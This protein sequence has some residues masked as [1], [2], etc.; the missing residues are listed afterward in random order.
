MIYDAKRNS[1]ID[2]ESGA[3]IPIY[4]GDAIPEFVKVQIQ[5]KND[6]ALALSL[7]RSTPVE[8]DKAGYNGIATSDIV[9]LSGSGDPRNDPEMSDEEFKRHE[10]LFKQHTSEVAR[11][12]QIPEGEGEDWSFARTLQAMEFEMFNEVY[13]ARVLGREFNEKE[14]RASSTRRQLLTVS[15]F[16]LLVQIGLLIAM[17]QEDGYASRSI[18]PTIGPNA[19]TLVRFG[20]KDAAL[21]LYQDEWFRLVSPIFLHAGIVHIISNGIIQLRIGGYLNLVYGTP[22]WVI[23]YMASGIFGNM[24][25][26]CFLPDAVSVGS[27]GALLGM[28]SSWLTWIIFRWRKIPPEA[29]TQRNCQLIVVTISIVV[30]LALSFSEYVDWGSHFGGSFQG[31]F[32]GLFFLSS[33]LDNEKTKLIL[34]VGSITVILMSFLWGIVY[35]LAFMQPS[36]ENMDYWE[37]N[38]D[39]N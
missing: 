22:K 33:E 12:G 24:M 32:L 10:E 5:V 9:L 17:V 14:Y 23:I 20:A 21:I 36:K 28:L 27:S 15:T 16:I 31:I 8:L 13:E 7:S 26:C 38:D 29:K 34:R 37:E 18:N 2:S 25:S 19:Y 30:T 11:N 6:E 1:L 35:M 4:D 39:W 3:V